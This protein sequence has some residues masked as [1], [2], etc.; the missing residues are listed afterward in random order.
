LRGLVHH[1]GGVAHRGVLFVVVLCL[2][3]AFWQR[4]IGSHERVTT[5]VSY[6]REIV[7]IVSRKCLSC[8]SENN[9]GIPLTTYEQTRPWSRAIQHEILTKHMPPWRAV[10]GFGQFA[11]DLALTSHELQVLVSWVEGNG[12]RT[13]G[14]TLVVNLDQERTDPAAALRL[15]AAKWQLGTPNLLENVT[16]P[17]SSQGDTVS[18]SVVHIERASNRWVRGLEFHPDDR[19]TIRAAFFRLQ[20]TGQWLGSWTPWYGFTTLPAGTSYWIPAGSHI[21]ADIYHSAATPPVGRGG[22]LGIYFA[23]GPATEAVEDVT[24]E[25]RRAEAKG[26]AVQA[27]RR[28]AGSARLAADTRILAFKPEVSPDFESLEVSAR[29]PDGPVQVLLLVRDALAEWPTPYIL[30][31]PVLLPQGSELTATY[32]SRDSAPDRRSFTLTVSTARPRVSPS[33]AVR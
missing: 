18:R 9:L 13:K 24:V 21:V 8:H 16:S 27:S 4:P 6:D 33:R 5:T 14:Q 17:G 26:V 3:W 28:F 2:C 15:D 25:S 19:R 23:A 11:N 32:Y 1:V 20:E 12:P 10:P 22:T 7:R 30:A 29:R 31:K